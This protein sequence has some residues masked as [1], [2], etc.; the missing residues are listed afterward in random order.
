M[1]VQAPPDAPTVIVRSK[2]ERPSLIGNW[3]RRP[4]IEA[5]LDRA[6]DRSLILITAP[7][8][9]GKT[10]TIV[11]WLGLHDLDAAWLTIDQ[12]DAELTRFA[13]HA[14]AALD[15]VCPGIARPLFTLLAAPDRVHASDLGEAFGEALYDLELDV[16]LVLDDF[17]A[18]GSDA[19]SA[20]VGGLLAAA[21]RRL[22][23]ILCTRARPPLSLAR[24]RTMGDVEELTGA[25]LRF[26]PDETGQLLQLELGVPVAPE[27]EQS[28]QASVGGWPAAVRLIALS[29]RDEERLRREPIGAIHPRLLDDY[30]GEEVLARLPAIHRQLLLRASLLERFNVS[31]LEALA[32][33]LGGDPIG[34]RDVERLRALELFREIPGL[35]ETWFAYHP[36]FRNVL[37]RELERTM[38]VARIADLR[39]RIAQALATEGLTRDAVEHLVAIG[40]IAA[41][42]ELIESR[43]VDAFAREDWRSIASWL[44][45]IPM[46]AVRESPELLLASA[47]IA[48]LSGRDARL[49]DILEAMREPEL[50][51]RATPAER[52]EIDLLATNPE[53]DPLVGIEVAENAIAL[54]PT[55]KRSRYG[56]AHLMLAL[57]LTSAGREDEAMARLAA[58]TERESAHIDAAS[59]RGYFGRLNVLRQAGR[60]ARC[61]QTAADQLQLAA[62]RGLPVTA[63][64]GAAFLGLTAF[65]RGDLAEA[66][67]HLGTVIADAGRVHFICL[68]DAFFVQIL[69]YEAQGLW[70]EADRAVA[71]LR[72]I[73]IASE[74]SHQLDLVDSFLARTALV[75]SDLAAAQRWLET[76]SAPDYVDFK[77]IEQPA[78]TRAKVLIALG[79]PKELAEAERL[80]DGFVAFA[81]SRYM[82]LALIEG[83]AVQAL[84]LEARGQHAAAA[85]TLRESIELAA[86][87]GIVQRYAYLGPG[88]APILRRLLAERAPH[89]HVRSVFDAWEKLSAAQPTAPGGL[90]AASQGT[91][92]GPLTDREIEVVRLLAL[93][94]TN[95]EIGDQLFI[96]PITVKHH[97]ANIAGK[98]GVSGRRAAVVRASELH[99]LP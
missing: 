53:S 2:I 81:R 24:L 91:Q 29:G 20:F 38:A 4:R 17:H 22:H 75:R 98:L 94:L 79:G 19:A 89:P 37:R 71:R 16:F 12:R 14:A 27:I 96:S 18:A 42:T 84:L 7:A 11:S 13:A 8:G 9:H 3:V 50:W 23:T 52:A 93:R 34:R 64:W 74:T 73:A 70:P 86:P 49:V 66:S 10:S 57:A 40:D 87:E 69:T 67:R 55:R 83:L 58:F 35:T 33:D 48:Y 82:A 76:S 43:L 63:G 1:S 56:Y 65:E 54:I 15:R 25:D 85:W 45:S 68:R 90:A 39:R 47:W 77:A 26:T 88:L 31:L 51:R 59:I 46:E 44:Q 80:L 60:L 78:L 97:V 41:A 99:I 30:L 32:I 62:M 36:L 95:N 5:R 92:A 6:F 28:V 72:E 61:E 21:P